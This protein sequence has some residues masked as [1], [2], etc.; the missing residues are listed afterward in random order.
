M[1]IDAHVHVPLNRN[2]WPAFPGLCRQNNV[3]LA[4]ASSLGIDSW[5]QYPCSDTIRGANECAFEFAGLSEGMV[6]WLAYLNPQ[7]E[8]WREELQTC[9]DKGAMG[10][11]LWVSLKSKKT[12]SLENCFPILE[13]AGR[14]NLSVLIHALNRYGPLLEGEICT[15]EFADL[16]RQFPETTMIQA[17]AGSDG[18]QGLDCLGDL[19][20]VYVDIS[21][22]FPRRGVLEDIRKKLPPSRILFGSDSSGAFSGRG[23]AAQLAKVFFAD[24]DPQEK[25]MILW[26]NAEKVFSIESN[27]DQ[28]E[29][30]VDIEKHNFKNTFLDTS[31]EHFC[32]AGSCPVFK[33]GSTIQGLDQ[34][35]EKNN[36][37]K[38]FT[39][40]ADSIYC[41][42][43]A[44]V[45]KAF[46][47]STRSFPR[48][49]PLATLNPLTKHWR[50]SLDNALSDFSG[51]FISPFLHNWQLDDIEY[52]EFFKA[53]A[54]KRFPLWINC[55]LGDKRFYPPG[56]A[57]RPITKEEIMSF[58]GLPIEN[59]YVFQGLDSRL[60]ECIIRT[61][62]F[63][64]NIRFDISRLTD[65]A[66]QLNNIITKSGASKL[67][68]GSEYPLKSMETVRWCAKKIL[69]TKIK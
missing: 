23:L 44:K 24:I 5:P 58:V 60:I 55:D 53:C 34:E 38:A 16:A 26:R 21:G 4:I 66:G 19:E 14:A 1:I 61:N 36:I 40:N 10:I 20:N 50:L 54:D 56:I 33:P 39:V 69:E 51:G 3:R 65:F 13:A 45:N 48:I 68:F 2:E 9:L 59:D 25:E 35:L 12:R 67:V 11:K 28:S 27:P 57:C 18:N 17:H 42:D 52:A 30:E 31:E 46:I 63:K 41:C 6:I 32:F 37:T 47:D 22:F 62:N 7:N 8:N 43:L 64:S 15:S 49:K 29:S